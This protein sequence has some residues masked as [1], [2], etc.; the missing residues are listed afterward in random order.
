MVRASAYLFTGPPQVGK[1]TV[2]RAFA[3]TLLCTGD[4]APCGVCRSCQLMVKERHP[5]FRL[6]PPTDSDGNVDRTNGVLR[7]EA[8][9]E[10]I[11]EAALRPVEGHYKVFL[12]QDAHLANATFSNKILKTLEEP[13]AHVVICVTATGAADLLPTIVSRCEVIELRPLSVAAARGGLVRGWQVE[14]T[15]AELLARLCNGRLGWAV[16]QLKDETGAATRSETLAEISRLVSANRI[17]RLRFAEKTA[18]NRDNLRLFNMLEL[19][20]TWWRD[21][22]LAQHGCTDAISN[23]DHQAEIERHA[24]ELF[25]RVRA[26]TSGDAET[27]GN[28]SSSHGEHASC[29]G[30]LAA[31]CAAACRIDAAFANPRPRIDGGQP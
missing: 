16:R 20:V 22:L 12:V 23:L 7:S 30:C 8:A 2:V 14:P 6:V 27:C 15:R 11:H 26:G 10:L 19:W 5:D 28:V 1:S 18:A 21:V 29:H 3:K 25:R 24:R 9:A 13:P 17:E 4:G 31:G